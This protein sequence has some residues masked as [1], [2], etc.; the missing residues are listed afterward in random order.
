MAHRKDAADAARRLA[1]RPGRD[2]ADALVMVS[3]GLM[4]TLQALWRSG[5]LSGPEISALAVIVYSDGV[6][7]RDLAALEQVTPATISRLVA[8]LEANGLVRRDADARD[9]RLQWIKATAIGARRIREG[10]ERRIAPLAHVVAA[11][12][13]EKR[14]KLEE[15][16]AILD[17]VIA[18][19]RARAK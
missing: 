9:A 13:R 10:H 3:V 6:A 5:D 15:A 16:A 17:E 14:R 7:A 19:V 2:L 12:P 11:L 8:G 18:E 4:R 1:D